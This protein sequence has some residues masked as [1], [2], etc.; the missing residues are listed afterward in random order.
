MIN[1]TRSRLTRALFAATLV[2]G[3]LGAPLATLAANPASDVA[4]TTDAQPTDT[5]PSDDATDDGFDGEVVFDP[6]FINPDPAQTPDATP[7]AAVKGAI[8]HPALTP[9]ATDTTSTPPGHA[10]GAGVPFLLAALVALTI[11][12]LAL[13]RIPAARRR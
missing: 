4:P 11:A 7:A 6:Y 9:P 10:G 12:V 2:L 13:G 8:G 5:P 3:L 1:Q